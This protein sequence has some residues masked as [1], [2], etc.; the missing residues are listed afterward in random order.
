[1]YNCGITLTKFRCHID[2]RTVE[3]EAGLSG[4]VS[5]WSVALRLD[6]ISIPSTSPARPAASMRPSVPASSA[7]LTIAGR[8][9]MVPPC[10]P[11]PPGEDKAGADVDEGGEP[12]TDIRAHD[13][14][15]LAFCGQAHGVK[16]P[17]E[18]HHGGNGITS[19]CGAGRGGAGSGDQFEERI[20][21]RSRD[22]APKARRI[23]TARR[24]SRGR[25]KILWRRRQ[26]RRAAD[27]LQ[28]DVVELVP[29]YADHV[30]LVDE[31]AGR[32]RRQIR[33]ALP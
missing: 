10:G 25:S 29:A 3:A 7:S 6:L 23:G 17:A 21:S 33:D 16:Q 12:S 31:R 32:G 1:M 4:A 11:R 18:I 13:E 27:R 26:S 24:P 2:T 8:F 20:V 15:R 28:V 14:Q 19:R 22:G 9:M 30:A 5:I